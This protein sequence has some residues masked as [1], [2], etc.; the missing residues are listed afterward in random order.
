MLNKHNVLN[1]DAIA[2]TFAQIALLAKAL[3]TEAQRN[4]DTVSPTISALASVPSE[5]VSQALQES[6]HDYDASIEASTSATIDTSFRVEAGLRKSE[7]IQASV[8]ILGT[9]QSGFGAMFLTAVQK[10]AN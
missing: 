2:K 10:G 3:E 7:I 5:H 6:A 9:I 1:S 8:V 4:G